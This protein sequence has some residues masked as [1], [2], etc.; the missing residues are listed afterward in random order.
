[1]RTLPWFE[2]YSRS[3]WITNRHSILNT[4]VGTLGQRHKRPPYFF[5]MYVYFVSLGIFKPV[6]ASDYVAG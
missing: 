6:D 1:M 3:R 2:A 5:Y 4:P